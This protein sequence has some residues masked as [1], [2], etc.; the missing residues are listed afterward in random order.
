M[1][2]RTPLVGYDWRLGWL[3]EG[4]MSFSLKSLKGVKKGIT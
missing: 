3:L 1:N 4:H 2:P